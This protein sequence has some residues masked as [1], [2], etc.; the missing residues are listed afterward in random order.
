MITDLPQMSGGPDAVR[1]KYVH[2]LRLS[3]TRT[4]AEH[5]ADP[6]TFNAATNAVPKPTDIVVMYSRPWHYAGGKLQSHDVA[7]R[8]FK[9]TILQLSRKQKNVAVWWSEE[10]FVITGIETSHLDPTPG[11]YPYTTQAPLIAT[12]ERDRADARDIYVVRATVHRPE[13]DHHMYKIV[14]T[15][16][17]DTI[18][19]DMSC[20]P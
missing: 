16:G 2:I 7:H 11:P 5:V 12:A 20:N 9:E 8:D 17:G 15:I 18:D 3:E 13:A 19:P 4:L 6:I 14:F 10:P 1:E